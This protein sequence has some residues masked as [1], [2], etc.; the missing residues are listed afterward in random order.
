MGDAHLQRPR[1]ARPSL[2]TVGPLRPFIET[3]IVPLM[4]RGFVSDVLLQ[5]MR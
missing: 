2:N 5:G 1:K 3:T 4:T